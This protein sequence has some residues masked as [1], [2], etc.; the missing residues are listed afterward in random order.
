MKKMRT[1]QKNT[2]N[3]KPSNKQKNT[4]IWTYITEWW[5]NHTNSTVS[6]FTKTNN[7]KVI[8][9][10]ENINNECNNFWGNLNKHKLIKFTCIVIICVIVLMIFFLSLKTYNRV[11]DLATYIHST[12]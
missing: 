1:T 5:T 4:K 3:P 10:S 7:P 8:I 2:W 9:K 6:V 12:M 11:N